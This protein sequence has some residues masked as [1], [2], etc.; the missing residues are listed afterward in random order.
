VLLKWRDTFEDAQNILP[1]RFRFLQ[2]A[3]ACSHLAKA[4]H[5]QVIWEPESSNIRLGL[6]DKLKQQVTKMK[7]AF[8]KQWM[9]TLEVGTDEYNLLKR[10][11]AEITR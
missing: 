7:E 11:Q 3:A 4:I 2:W 1:E 9:R 5:P 10:V 8:Q 6:M